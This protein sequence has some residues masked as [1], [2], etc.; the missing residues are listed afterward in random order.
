MTVFSRK[1]MTLAAVVCAVVLVAVAAV[2]WIA[3]TRGPGDYRITAHVESSTGIYAGDEVTVL[4]VPVGTIERIKPR[5]LDVAVTL[6]VDGDVDLPQEVGAAVVAQSL[7]AGRTLALTPAYTSGPKL[8]RNASIPLSR[9]TVP[10]EW[11][12]IKNAL[13]DVTKAIG[14]QGDGDPGS[15]ATI[16]STG[17]DTLAPH[18]QT[19]NDTIGLLSEAMSTISDG[20]ADLFAVVR[21]LQVFVTAMRGSNGQVADL[22][23]DLATVTSVLG[24]N[25]RT[26]GEA[27]TAVDEVLGEV[28]EFVSTNGDKLTGNV[29]SLTALSQV[30]ADQ[31]VNIEGIMHQAPT[32]VVN[33]YN[34]YKPALGVMTG[35]FA[36]PNFENPI[37]AVCGGLASVGQPNSRRA[38]DLCVQ[39]FGTYLRTLTTTYPNIMTSPSRSS[40][41][42][43][44]QLIESVPGVTSS[45][46]GISGPPPARTKVPKTLASLLL[47]EGS[48]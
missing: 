32:Q 27:I 40:F 5:A 46:P 14:P 23:R 19:F 15:A 6:R 31:R 8:A 39:Y 26:M 21:N 4:G 2:W 13:S 36:A 38:A 41:S 18:A 16:V 28:T 33:F 44:G 48:R 47:G 1:R 29:Q 30:L 12:D 7:V 20:R 11:D 45:V 34:I 42:D 43:P 25:R 35:V 22:H 3:G 9:T 24:D 17:A 37:H 10:M